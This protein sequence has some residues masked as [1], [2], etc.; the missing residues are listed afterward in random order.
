[1]MNDESGEW[2]VESF[3]DDRPITLTARS[4]EC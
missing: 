4:K 2:K 1:M 3:V